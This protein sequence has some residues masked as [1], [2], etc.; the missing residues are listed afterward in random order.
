MRWSRSVLDSDKKS[1]W[2]QNML[3]PPGKHI[4]QQK[5]PL[6]ALLHLSVNI[7]FLSSFRNFFHLA[8]C[9]ADNPKWLCRLFDMANMAFISLGVLRNSWPVQSESVADRT[10]LVTGK[11][12]MGRIA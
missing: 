2:E 5:V 10:A 12:S 1:A 8:M 11:A 6:T 9:S 4:L 7:S 3:F